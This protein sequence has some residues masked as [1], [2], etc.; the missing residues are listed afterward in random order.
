M[1]FMRK[2]VRSAR[3]IFFTVLI[4]GA[5]S[6]I[7]TEPAQ[8]EA[9][10]SIE[11]LL[12]PDGWADITMR[13]NLT[14]EEVFAVLPIVGEPNLLIATDEEGLPLNFTIEEGSLVVETLGAKGLEVS[15]QSPSL[16]SKV[17]E[18]WNASVSLEVPAEVTFVLPE[19]AVVVGL[20][21]TPERVE[22][23]DGR[24]AVTFVS[25]HAWV[26]YVIELPHAAPT[27]TSPPT[28]G[29]TTPPVANQRPAP[30][31]WYVFPLVA[32]GLAVVTFA[33]VKAARS[34]EGRATRPL[35]RSEELI[36]KKL[37]EM[38]G[39]AYQ[40]DLIRAL[41]MPRTTAWRKIRRLAQAG[42]LEIREGEK[43]RLVILKRDERS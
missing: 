29:S 19:G 28:Q 37:E 13:L 26:S 38:G 4:I 41:G 8:G 25:Q 11:L 40:A 14:G 10:M 6:Q 27:G 20:S 39:M 1:K 17:G 33:I 24:V 21:A 30:R 3:L 23:E 15:Y 34:P 42:I 43:G 36:L 35:E 16:T 32:V 5:V 12:F 31:E 9:V 18:V 7:S 22:A 2:R